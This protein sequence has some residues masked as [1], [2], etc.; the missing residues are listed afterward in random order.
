MAKAKSSPTSTPPPENRGRGRWLVADFAPVS[1]FSLKTAYA[2]NKGGKTLVVPT[3]YSVKMAMLDACFRRFG[4]GNADARA[5]EMFEWIKWRE[6]RVR[7]PKHCVVQ[8]TFIK[9][10][11]HDRD[12]TLPF[13]NTIAYREF[14]FFQGNLQ[15]AVAAG[16]AGAYACAAA[17]LFAHINYL[18]K[19]GG[20]WQFL[21]SETIEGDLPLGF[22]T[23]I[24]VPGAF[25]SP[26]IIF[27]AL[28]DFGD[29]LC[30]AKDGFDRV[31]TYGSGTIKLGEHRVLK[32]TA[33]TYRKVGAS[34]HYT[35]YRRSELDSAPLGQLR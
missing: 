8:Q 4:P 35:W 33:V 2:T 9:I 31:S 6:V 12:G 20:F 24:D 27:Q 1:L 25:A 29:A 28:D 21:A 7:P 13:K 19:R 18:G 26:Y 14:A 10:L 3:P 23:P 17:E 11:D 34:R 15:I 30:A 16:G 5:R 32:D 22:S